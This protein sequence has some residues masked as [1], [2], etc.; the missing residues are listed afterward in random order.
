MSNLDKLQQLNTNIPRET[1]VVATDGLV[2]KRPVIKRSGIAPKSWLNKQRHAQAVQESLQEKSGKY[3]FIPKM[4]EISDSQMFAIE[5]RVPGL[6]VTDT[7]FETLDEADRAI[8][9]L[10]FAHFLNDINQSKPVLTQRDTFD[11]PEQPGDVAFARIVKHLKKNLSSKEIDILNKSK[12][13]FD[14]NSINDAS[15]VFCQGD[16]NQH[17]IFYDQKTKTVSFIDFADA[18][19][20][21]ARD[22]FHRDIAR[23]T[24][25]D[26]GKLIQMYKGLERTQPVVTESE[27]TVARMRNALQNIK[28]CGQEVLTA[29]QRLFKARLA[30]LK[31]EIKKLGNL[32]AT[33]K[34]TNTFKNALNALDNGGKQK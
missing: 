30:I 28:W 25:L 33:V 21:N 16:M 23:L 3:Y 10:G 7:Y 13:W 29:D 6:P 11:N 4:L 14:A 12:E 31:E 18:R 20:E 5:Q 19:Y 32:L 8:I 27:P 2:I 22:M 17:N 9:Y 26:I 1:L 15:V 24:W 34:A